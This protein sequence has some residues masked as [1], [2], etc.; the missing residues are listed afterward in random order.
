MLVYDRNTQRVEEITEAS[1]FPLEWGTI[2]YHA[3][4]H[5]QLT[6]SLKTLGLHPLESHLLRHYAGHPKISSFENS[7]VISLV[8]ITKNL[9]QVNCTLLVGENYVITLEEENNQG[10]FSDLETDFKE[11]P[12]HMENTGM[13]L[14]SIFDCVMDHYHSTM[15]HIF[16]QIDAIEKQVF[17]TPFENNIGKTIYQIKRTCHKIGQFLEALDPI[18]S[19][20][21]LSDFPYITPELHVYFQDLSHRLQ[22]IITTTHQFYENL[23]AIFNLQLSLK[24]DHT[25]TIVKT[26]SLFNVIFIPMTF[27][28]GIYGMNFENI[29][30]YHLRYGF[31]YVLILILCTGILIALYFKRKGWWGDSKK[32]K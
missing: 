9:A 26:L 2:W 5:K 11:H 14:Y 25:N 13:I 16:N 18:M 23:N 8:I 6:H 12:E 22:L 1:A 30:G 27:I 3:N 7:V 21:T 24:A 20:M 29:P 32:Q 28:A 10:L 19:K 4:G 31:I 15:D 17:K